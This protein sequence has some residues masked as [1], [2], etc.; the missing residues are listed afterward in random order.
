MSLQAFIT[1]CLI[2]ERDTGVEP[3]SSACLPAVRFGAGYQIR[4]GVST[5]E[6]WHTATVLIP[7]MLAGGES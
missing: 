5:L 7:L 1:T 4:T 6:G 3:V 2:F